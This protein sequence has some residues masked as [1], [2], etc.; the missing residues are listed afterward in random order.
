MEVNF[1]FEIGE[2]VRAK[3]NP[4][5]KM[6]I[7]KRVFDQCGG[8]VQLQYSVRQIICR[9]SISEL[10]REPTSVF[11]FELEKEK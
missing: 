1:Q 11:E 8:G 2:M 6:M 5:V 10:A 7:L 3:G 9:S 4:S